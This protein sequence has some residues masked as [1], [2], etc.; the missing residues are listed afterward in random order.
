M[1]QLRKLWGYTK[2]FLTL[3]VSLT[4]FQT[5]LTYAAPFLDANSNTSGALSVGHS[6]VIPAVTFDT[7]KTLIEAC[8]DT[9]VSQ[10]VIIC[11][12]EEEFLTFLKET[13]NDAPYR[14]SVSALATNASLATV[15]QNSGRDARSISLESFATL[16]NIDTHQTISAEQLFAIEYDRRMQYYK[17][18]VRVLAAVLQGLYDLQLGPTTQRAVTVTPQVQALLASFRT[19]SGDPIFADSLSRLAAAKELEDKG[20]RY[21]FIKDASSWLVAGKKV[22]WSPSDQS[23]LA[24][25]FFLDSLTTSVLNTYSR[26]PLVTGAE[27]EI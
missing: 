11:P 17:S 25:Y 5:H 18:D 22:H 14:Y 13:R 26:P 4:I 20:F 10:N 1:I 23:Q 21:K 12:S 15:T 6:E 3:G 8:Y 19:L 7:A 27:Q 16:H 9:S 24:L 2:I